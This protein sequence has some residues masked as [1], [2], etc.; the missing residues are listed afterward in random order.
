MLLRH[1]IYRAINRLL[2]DNSCKNPPRFGRPGSVHTKECIKKICEKIGKNLQCSACT[3]A[4]ENLSC[5]IKQ[6]IINED[7]GFSPLSQKK[8]S[9]FDHCTNN[10]KVTKW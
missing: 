1:F 9:R 7:L 4:A 3:M 10:R 2:N 8:S 6:A 5:T